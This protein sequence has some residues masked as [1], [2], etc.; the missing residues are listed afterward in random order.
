MTAYWEVTTAKAG[1][2]FTAQPVSGE[3]SLSIPDLATP[4]EVRQWLAAHGYQ[5][6][7]NNPDLWA[8]PA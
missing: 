8:P 4:L 5:S 6:V 2:R 3:P 1:H 7:G